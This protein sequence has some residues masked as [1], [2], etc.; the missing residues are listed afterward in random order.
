MSKK[1][2]SPIKA[3]RLHCLN[4]CCDQPREVRLCG[5]VGC[6]SHPLRMGKSVP[7]LRPLQVI[8][9]H[10][11]ACGGHEEHPRDCTVTDCKL[12]PFR[13]GKN[14]NRAGIGNH[15][16]NQANLAQ[17]SRTHGA[18]TE[19]TP[20]YTNTFTCEESCAVLTCSDRRG[21]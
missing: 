12:F 6:S 17:K 19:R 13:L 21:R 8:K 18:K 14:P 9:A 10:C 3:I 7:G 1:H 15:S 5:A 2:S 11:I 20:P 16:P 4:C